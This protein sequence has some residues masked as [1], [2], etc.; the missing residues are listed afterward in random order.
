MS[1]H[2]HRTTLVLLIAT[3]IAACHKKQ[4][5]K[6]KSSTRLRQEA[7]AKA[8]EEQAA[9]NAFARS[10]REVMVWHESQPVSTD[11][12]RQQ[13]IKVLAGKME[14]VPVKGLP[15]D[16]SEAWKEML[17]SWQ[18]LARTAKPDAGLVQRGTKAAEELNRQLSVRGVM[19]LRF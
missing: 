1:R 11:A 19:D 3:A 7:I 17:K 18:E 16:F 6:K 13:T 14:K 5:E 10:V 12:E 9:L 15:D 8:C 2:L 4:P